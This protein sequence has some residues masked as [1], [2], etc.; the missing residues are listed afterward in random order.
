MGDKINLIEIAGDYF[1]EYWVAVQSL[2]LFYIF[3]VEARVD[4]S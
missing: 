2:T 3:L 1:S 4:E